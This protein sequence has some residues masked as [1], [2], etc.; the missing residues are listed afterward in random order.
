VD[1]STQVNA[2]GSTGAVYKGLALASN[3]GSDFLYAANFRSGNI[4]VFDNTFKPVTLP[5]GA[6]H[7]PTLPSGFA[8]FGIQTINGNLYVTFAKQDAAKHDEVDGAGLGFVDV[9]SPAGFF[10]QRIGG[11]TTQPELNAPWGLAMAPANFGK[12]SGDLLVGN[13]G[14]SHV[15]AFDPISGAFLGQLSNAKGQ[16]LVLDGGFN[17]SS[18]QGLWGLSFGNNGGAGPAN[19]LYFTSGFNHESD[20]VLGAVTAN[21]VSTATGSSIAQVDTAK[22]SSMAQV[23]TSPGSTSTGLVPI[24]PSDMGTDLGSVKKQGQHAHFDAAL[25]ALRNG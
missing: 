20:G 14:D 13:F 17:G 25:E 12:F 23:N 11:T 18:T 16:P 1:N 7:D 9:F 2:N 22:G 3:G 4:D 10:L 8:P 24:S 5:T 21:S 15:S 19:T 6:F